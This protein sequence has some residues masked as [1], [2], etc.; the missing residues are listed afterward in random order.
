MQNGSIGVTTENIFPIIKKFLYSDHEIFLREI[1]SNAV[2]ATQKIKTLASVGEFKGDLGDLTIQVKVDK[3][4]GTITVA[5][6]GVGMTEDEMSR[7]LNQI[8]FSG[9]EEFVEKYKNE[10]NNII[11]HF[12]LGFYSSFM[13]SSK[14]DVISKS[15]KD[16]SNGVKWSCDGSPEFTMEEASKSERGTEIIMHIDDDNKEFLEEAKISGLLKK[17]C[18]FLPIPIAFG[19]KK[20]WKDGK[21]VETAED[22]VVNNVSPAWTRKP[23]EL[24]EE[25]YKSFYQEL[26]PYTDEPLFHIH[27]NVDYPFTL[28]GILYFPKIKSN[29]DLHKNKI[30][31]Y[32]NQVFVSDSV[33]GIVPEFMTLLHGV[34]DSPDIPLNVSRSYLQ[35]DSNVKK[36]SSHITKKVADRLQ[37]LFKEDRSQF[38]AK[39]DDLKIFV[40]YGELTDEKFFE[41]AEKFTLLKNSEN[42]YFTLEEYKKLVEGNQSDKDNQLIY[43]YTTNLDQ[44][45]SYID[46]AKEKGYDVLVMDGQL[47]VHFISKIEEKEKV[48]FVRVD[49][50]VVDNLIRKED[51][52]KVAWSAEQKSALQTVFKSQTP[53]LDKVEFMVQF[54]A[55]GANANPVLLTQNEYM[56]RM[57]EMSASQ[58]GFNFYGEMPDSYNL[59]VNTN[60]PLAQRV[61]E[62]QEAACNEKLA[63]VQAELTLAEAKRD[64]LQN[65]QKGKKD[66][67]ISLDDKEALDMAKKKVE[68][69]QAN[70]EALLTTYA[71]EN[72]L[73]SQLIDLA[74]LSNNMLKGEALSNFVKRSFQMI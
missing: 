72:K 35:S 2:D 11:G 1:I 31:L 13:V 48:R 23:S 49:S 69:L 9:A 14:V 32:C 67:E 39:W 28:T 18:S 46:A 7:Y 10:A 64:E 6:R 15:F 52:A 8:A 45:Y 65:S 51:A 74:L 47:D 40:E 21:D 55:L 24:K 5:D 17:Y 57:K 44:Q 56:R 4:K 37:E 71:K 62:D 36:I 60:H 63:P 30:Q 38:E 12:G 42:S 54:E 25:D 29:V 20:E 27:L 16:D 59:V 22:N 19:K 68:E 70:R 43:L 26:Y 61:L 3:E 58:T 73:V 50:D 34:I 33:E 41:R 53:T 66:E